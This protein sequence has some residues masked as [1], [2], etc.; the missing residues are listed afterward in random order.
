MER[1][2]FNDLPAN[3]W[4][5]MPQKEIDPYS[6]EERDRSSIIIGPIARIG[7]TRSFTSDSGQGTWPS[8]CTALKWG[9]VDLSNGK[10]M[11]SLSPA[12]G[13]REC[14][15]DGGEPANHNAAS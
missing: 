6:E 14:A 11:L 10:A 12:P 8:E 7:P 2:P 5:R 9:S 13:R 4:R 15:K 3:W 1:N